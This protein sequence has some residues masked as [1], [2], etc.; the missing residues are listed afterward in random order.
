MSKDELRLST[1]IQNLIDKKSNLIDAISNKIASYCKEAN[2]TSRNSNE[3][4]R[5]LKKSVE[6]LPVEDR[7]DIFLKALVTLSVASNANGGGKARGTSDNF[8][9]GRF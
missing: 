7:A 6:D 2:A 8:F 9:N 3:I 5:T 4:L 1:E